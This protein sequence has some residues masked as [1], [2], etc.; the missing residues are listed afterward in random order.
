MSSNVMTLCR[1]EWVFVVRRAGAETIGPSADEALISRQ[2]RRD[3]IRGRSIIRDDVIR[4]RLHR[5]N[6]RACASVCVCVRLCAHFYALCSF[7]V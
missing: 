3:D 2:Y 1:G 6:S 5:L 7:A 4:L